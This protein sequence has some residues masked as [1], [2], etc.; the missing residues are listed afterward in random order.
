MI[1]YGFGAP[2]V[3]G[4]PL[5]NSDPGCGVDELSAVLERFP[6]MQNLQG[7]VYSGKIL[8]ANINFEKSFRPS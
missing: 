5:Q 4:G 7:T 8:L 3:L 6:N 2:F 1:R